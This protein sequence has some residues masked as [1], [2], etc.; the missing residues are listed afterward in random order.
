MAQVYLTVVLAP[1]LAA[2]VAGL[3]G[4]KIGRAGAHWVTIIGVAVSFALSLAAFKD[5]VLDGGE[6]YDGTVV[7]QKFLSCL[8]RIAQVSRFNVGLNHVIEILT[9]ADTDKIRRW[10]H[11]RLSTYGLLKGTTRATLRDWIFQL[12]SQE[13]LVQA[14]DEYPV[15]KLNAASWEVLRG[16]RHGEPCQT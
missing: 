3:F 1:L 10:G 15:L 11:D 14:G 4:K 16:Q 6:T 5:L 13:V 7:A 8:Y 12:I 9:G 2:A